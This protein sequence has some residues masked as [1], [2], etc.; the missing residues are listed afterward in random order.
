MALIWVLSSMRLEGLPVHRVPLKDKGVHFVEFGVLGFFA[1]HAVR[2]TWGHRPVGRLIATA[3]LIAFGWGVL[4]ELHQAFV[5]G[6][7]GDVRDI[8]AD[9]LGSVAGAVALFVFVATFGKDK[10]KRS[11]AR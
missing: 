5:P 6:R 2:H 1:A 4:D 7:N 3:A 8:I 10:R 9:A 11:P